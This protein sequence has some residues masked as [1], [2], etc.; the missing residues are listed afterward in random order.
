MFAGLCTGQIYLFILGGAD[1]EFAK[2][3]IF[4]FYNECCI[5]VYIEKTPEIKH[6]MK[7]IWKLKSARPVFHLAISNM[8]QRHVAFCERHVALQ[9]RHVALRVRHVALRI[10]RQ[11]SASLNYCY[12]IFNPPRPL[13]QWKTHHWCHA[14]TPMTQYLTT[15]ITGD[16][17]V[18]LLN[19]FFLY[20]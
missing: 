16:V 7:T 5:G 17:Y 9:V 1:L 18:G 15:V 20:P 13:S 2:Q 8:A 12:V 6:K 3:S 10:F 19:W 14:L 4:K 11:W